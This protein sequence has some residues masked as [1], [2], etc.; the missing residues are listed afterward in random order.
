[1]EKRLSVQDFLEA[2][3]PRRMPLRET[4]E[5]AQEELELRRQRAQG[6]PSALHPGDPG[7]VLELR[8]RLWSDE[9]ARNRQLSGPDKKP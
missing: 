7:F 6:V 1:M 3:A 2:A 5:R 8:L 4:I 9:Q